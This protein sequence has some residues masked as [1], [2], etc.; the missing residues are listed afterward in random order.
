MVRPPTSIVILAF[1]FLV[2]VRPG[3]VLDPVLGLLVE[4]EALAL[5]CFELLELR[6]HVEERE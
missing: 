3:H 5:L 2:K 6:I 4:A 1:S